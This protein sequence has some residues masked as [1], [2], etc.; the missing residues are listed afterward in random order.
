MW[1]LLVTSR[2]IY[3]WCSDDFN[4]RYRQM[5]LEHTQS[6]VCIGSVTKSFTATRFTLPN[7]TYETKSLALI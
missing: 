4:T 2:L 1:R 5:V 3:V 7:S 6:I